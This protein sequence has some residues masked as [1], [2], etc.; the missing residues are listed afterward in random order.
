MEALARL[1]GRERLLVELLVFKLVELRQLLLAGETRF[2]DWAA[3]EVER[4]TSSVRLTEIERAV[5]VTG[6]GESRGL[7]E[8]TLSELISDCSEPWR[9]L[10]D[11]DSRVLR[12]SA[13]EVCELLQ[14][15]RRLADAG[16][17]SIADILGTSADNDTV[18]TTY[19]PHATR[20][21]TA[22]TSRLNHVL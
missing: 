17:R 11:D 5:L 12:E 3:E 15:T 4:A 13:L 22:P 6:L 18:L 20:D 19:G 10:L 21:S 16:A 7:D 14:S 9:S 2:L 8:P 1:L